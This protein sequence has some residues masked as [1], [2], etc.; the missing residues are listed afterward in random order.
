MA[1][2][3]GPEDLRQK[4][5]EKTLE[6]LFKSRHS[7]ERDRLWWGVFSKGNHMI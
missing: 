2:P 1:L 4:M 6:A 7:I 5:H 3:A